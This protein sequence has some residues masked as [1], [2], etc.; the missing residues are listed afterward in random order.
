M[1]I[2]LK[3]KQILGKN[4]YYNI[5]S[6]LFLSLNVSGTGLDGYMDGY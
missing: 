4:L 3:H 5:L 1:D 6:L 2:E